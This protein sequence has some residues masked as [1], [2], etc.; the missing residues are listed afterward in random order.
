[1]SETIH[2]TGDTVA[3]RYDVVE[4]VG[5]GGMQEVYRANDG[6]MIREVALK[7]PKNASAE[8]RFKRSAMLSARVSHPN[9]A[10]TLDYLEYQ[11]RP[12]LIEEFIDG[13]DL[14]ALRE[15]LPL[16]DPS[17]AA[18]LFHHMARGVAASHHVDVVHRD[19]KPSNIMVARNLTF[20]FVKITDFGIAKMSE[21]EIATAAE[22]GDESITGSQTM[23]GALPYMAPEMIQSPRTTGKASDIWA[24]ASVAYELL[25]GKKPFGKGLLAVPQIM[26]GPL[27][28]PP[29]FKPQFRG[30]GEAL[31][32]ILKKCWERDP[33][34]RPTA[35][36]LV[37]MCGD[38][39]YPLTPRAEG[40]LHFKPF[41]SAGFI[42]TPN[43]DVFFHFASVYGQAP[44][45]GDR[46]CF[47]S[48]PG[49]PSPRAHPVI[50]MNVPEAGTA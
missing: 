25:T 20:S 12:Y 32:E 36:A 34:K 2:R 4:Y 48:F 45:V 42:G 6:V 16:M 11:G 27:P 47:A 49:Y 41:A 19:L 39:C 38:L 26:N 3:G 15:R 37:Q 33:E 31:S 8:R 13:E 24:I 10:K 35:D 18:H 40:T 28:T 50:R 44:K 29:A 30:L 22:G 46:V 9:A 23:M 43:G 1:V 21:E 5:A 17:L 14:W 7:V